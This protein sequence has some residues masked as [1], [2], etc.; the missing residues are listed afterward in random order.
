MS[1]VSHRVVA[2]V[3]S[4]VCVGACA[5]ATTYVS[6]QSVP[7]EHTIT[8]AGTARVELVPDEACV[9]LT[10][11]AR[12]P[13]MPAAHARLTEAHDAL[14]AELRQNGALA[15]ENGAI[16][17][18]P[19]YESDGNGRSHLA[20]HV[21]TAQVNVRTRDFARIPDVVGRAAARGLERVE[22]VYYS[23]EIVNRRAEVRGKALDA[24][25]EKARTM[26]AA[27]DTSL[28]EV[29]TISEGEARTNARIEVAN[30][31]E[32]ANTDALPD[33]P[34]MPGAI[35]LTMSVSV[36]YRLK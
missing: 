22:V 16:Q 31:L 36:V 9:E 24:A 6:A 10:L 12:D 7:A 14:M 11:A 3:L 33:A 1:F 17:Y 26:A 2:L 8:V 19:E 20:R 5:P 35:P 23:T 30:Y 13:S 15:V 27:L 21:A 18:A 32:R 29:I 25:R 34:P 4:V 28:A